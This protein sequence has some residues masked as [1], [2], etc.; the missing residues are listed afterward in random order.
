MSVAVDCRAL[1]ASSGQ[2][3]GYCD[4]YNF[5][6]GGSRLPFFRIFEKASSKRA[7]HNF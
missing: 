1:R 4:S 3:D 5:T 7:I 2:A 6:L